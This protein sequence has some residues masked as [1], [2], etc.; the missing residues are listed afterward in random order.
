[1][2]SGQAPL[3]GQRGLFTFSKGLIEILSCPVI[4]GL[5]I[6]AMDLGAVSFLLVV[7]EAALR[8]RQGKCCFYSNFMGVST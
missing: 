2:V 8:P 5:Q 4:D 6:H 7:A 1:M 3:R